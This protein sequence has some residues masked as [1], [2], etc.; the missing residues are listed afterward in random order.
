MPL[1]VGIVGLP[2]VGKSTF[3]NAITNAGAEAQNYPF[4]T[5]EPNTGIVPVPDPRLEVLAKISGTKKIIPATI[6]CVDIAGLVKGAS[7]GEGLGNKFL[8]HIREVSAIA[9]VVR[10]FEDENIV[11]VSGKISPVDDIEVI[12]TELTL[13]DL[14]MADKMH[15]NAAKA[16]RSGATAEAKERF[17]VL[18]K[19]KAALEGGKCLR[20]IPFNAEEAAILFTMNFI[21]AK[22]VI[23][24]AN[25]S[26]SMIG[27]KSPQVDAVKAYAEREGAEFTVI[28]AKIEDEIA[29]LDKAEK[30]EFLKEL[31]IAESGL[32]IFAHKCYHLLGLQT[33]M[34]TG[35][36]ETHAWTINKGDTAPKAAGVIH[37]DFEKGFI[38]ANIMSY[39]DLVKYGSEK[40]V[41]EKGLMRQE[42]REYV[43][44]EGDIVEFLF[45]V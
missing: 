27:Q 45:N 34:T 40:V 13:A 2:N 16:M 29:K 6:S 41:K 18:E 21:T 20:T 8:S 32:D 10:C 1:S 17:A 42:G 7:K 4:C 23:Y 36:Q 15:A 25:I 5:I 26:D 44:Q 24:V 38:R 28:C 3:F 43:M 19:V 31:G 9:H 30:V 11:H 39:D 14:E 12:N 22:K 33:Y 37:T 35:V